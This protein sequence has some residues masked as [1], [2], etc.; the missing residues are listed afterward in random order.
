MFRVGNTLTLIRAAAMLIAF[1]AAPLSAQT[2]AACPANF[3]GAPDQIMTCSCTPAAA[4]ANATVWGTDT[5]THDS[6]IC[7]AALHAG[8][9]N[10]QGGTILVVPQVGLA[11][12]PGSARNGVT[13]QNWGAYWRAF[14]VARS[15][16]Q[17]LQRAQAQLRQAGPAL[18]RVREQREREAAEARARQQAQQQAQPGQ[19]ATPPRGVVQGLVDQANQ[20]IGRAAQETGRVVD[21]VNQGLG[22]QTAQVQACPASYTPNAPAFTCVCTEAQAGAGGVWGTDIYTTDSSICRAAVHAGVIPAGGGVV[23]TSPEA[24]QQ[25]YPGSVRNGVTSQQWG[26]WTA[27]FR[28]ARATVPAPVAQAPAPAPAAKGPENCPRTMPANTPALSCL[29]TPEMLADAGGT[30]WG[31]DTYTTDSHICRAALHA[32]AVAPSGG[33]V[34]VTVAPGQQSYPPSARNGVTSMQWGNWGS[35]LVFARAAPAGPP[36]VSRQDAAPGAAK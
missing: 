31:T 5:Y 36:L 35:S 7:R 23:R 22:G 2:P 30:V 34:R 13:T 3:S 4:A 9:I 33:L 1:G 27:S 18:A 6:A 10:A 28:V 19:P 25:A 17:N 15:T 16:P 20:Q 24:G 14:T 21:Q 26:N 12:Y 11:T 32:G 29:C 8:V